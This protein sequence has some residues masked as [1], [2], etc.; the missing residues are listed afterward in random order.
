MDECRSLTQ[1]AWGDNELEKRIQ[2][3]D[4]KE[5]AARAEKRGGKR[6]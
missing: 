3:I 5:N 2:V 6:V 1:R 4:P